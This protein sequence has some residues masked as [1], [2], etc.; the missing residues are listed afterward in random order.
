MGLQIKK[1]SSGTGYRPTWYIRFRNDQGIYVSKNTGIVI[2]GTPPASLALRDTGDPAFERSRARAEIFL[3]NFL[4]ERK[5]KGAAEEITKTLIEEKTG[6]KITYS[7]IDELYS[8]W[9]NF[10]RARE[11]SEDR[12]TTSKAIFK[13][14]ADYLKSS[15]VTTS[16]TYL[17]EVTPEAAKGFIDSVKSTLTTSTVRDYRTLLSGAFRRLLPNG[18]QNPF[19]DIKVGDGSAD[20]RKIHR[21]P[22]TD[23]ELEKLY[24]TAKKSEDPW[25][26]PV[27]ICAAE[28]G[29]RI[30]DVCQL[31]W[32]DVYLN[33]GR[34]SV[35]TSKTGE[36]VDLP[37]FP[38]LRKVFEARIVEKDPSDK[39]VFPEAAS[40]YVH[41]KTGIR[42]RGKKLFAEALF[43][44]AKVEEKPTEVVN[45]IPKPP[46][47]ESEVL[48]AIDG[49]KFIAKKKALAKDVYSRYRHGQTYTQIARELG[50]LRSRICTLLKNIEE[51]TGEKIRPWAQADEK[52]LHLKMTRQEH[53][54]G[55][56]AVSIYGWHSLR[57]TFCVRA[58]Q[59]GVPSELIRKAVGHK[60]FETTEKYYL[61]PTWEVFRQAW[62][63]GN[64]FPLIETSS[65][66]AI[67]APCQTS[68]PTMDVDTAKRILASLTLE[69]RQAVSLLARRLKA[70]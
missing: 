2:A 55:K 44:D 47:T 27:T 63:G 8:N 43:G 42:T 48:A 69:Q 64:G 23:E 28:T 21:K 65:F 67:P 11:V 30:G 56:N 60:T 18:V 59:R 58:S 34:L 50:I 12:K 49:S 40:M 52:Q 20:S 39:H 37:I 19:S 68:D 41:N 7:R 15:P 16:W 1:N 53:Q 26:L 66:R 9:L 54:V 10:S 32:E 45:G 6:R 24:E 5:I 3:E 13:K 57:A 4:R 51:L 14:F 61:H 25:L 29:L 22:L 62:N 17:Y 35:D 36:R 33:E 38:E 70:S 31:K 46:M